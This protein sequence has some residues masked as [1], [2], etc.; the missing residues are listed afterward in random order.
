VEKEEAMGMA[1]VVT[2]LVVAF[3]EGVEMAV[4]ME[5][6]VI[7]TIVDPLISIRQL[8]QRTQALIAIGS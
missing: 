6:A 4:A 3:L 1:R 5:A 2:V 8:L 7:L